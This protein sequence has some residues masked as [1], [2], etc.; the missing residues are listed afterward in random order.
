MTAWQDAGLVAEKLRLTRGI[1]AAVERMD[2]DE[3]Q[4]LQTILQSSLSAR[5]RK[6]CCFV[7]GLFLVCLF[8]GWKGVPSMS[9]LLHD[10][11]SRLQDAS[12]AGERL[13]QGLALELKAAL[14]KKDCREAARIQR[15]LQVGAGGMA[16]TDT[17]EH[18]VGLTRV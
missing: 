16:H 14:N 11:R 13:K 4:R 2:Y 8:N 1:D 6:D 12:L 5:A 18:M 9:Q 17:C 15:L 10:T 3:A 7:F